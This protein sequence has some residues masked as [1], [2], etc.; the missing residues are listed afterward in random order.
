MK[1]W[2]ETQH[3]GSALATAREEIKREKYN[4]MRQSINE[5]AQTLDCTSL[6]TFI[7]SRGNSLNVVREGDQPEK[8][9]MLQ[10]KKTK[11]AEISEQIDKDLAFSHTATD[12]L[13]VNIEAGK[14]GG[15]SKK[16]FIAG[17]KP[18]KS[19]TKPTE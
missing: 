6:G 17:H 7:P 15:L 18:M 14:G 11:I 1:Q 10:R 16:S 2:D 12:K 13:Q 9:Q 19:L 5:K 3:T 8:R 4:S